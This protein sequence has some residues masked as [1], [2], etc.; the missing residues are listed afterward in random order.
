MHV[1]DQLVA[2]LHEHQ[3]EQVASGIRRSRR[4]EGSIV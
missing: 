2:N 1:G 3:A 4:G